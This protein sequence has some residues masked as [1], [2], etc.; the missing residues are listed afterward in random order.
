MTAGAV[1][2]NRP[3]MLQKVLNDLFHFLRANACVNIPK[4]LEIILEG[5]NTHAQDKYIQISGMYVHASIIFFFLLFFVSL[6]T[7]KYWGTVFV[8]APLCSISYAI[9]IL[10]YWRKALK[11][12]SSVRCSIAW[13]YIWK[14]KPCWGTVVWRYVSLGYLRILW[15]CRRLYTEGGCDGRLRLRTRKQRI[16]SEGVCCSFAWDP[17]SVSRSGTK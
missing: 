2:M 16:S 14:T 3:Q 6:I 7:V 17:I 9:R 8:T 10:N 11:N 12:W 4:I 13:R 1:Y 5:L 15:V